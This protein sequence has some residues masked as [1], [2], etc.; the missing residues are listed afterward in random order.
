MQPRANIKYLIDTL[1]TLTH[2][3]IKPEH[4]FLQI[5]R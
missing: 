3:Q 4:H 2:Q 1:P 5:K